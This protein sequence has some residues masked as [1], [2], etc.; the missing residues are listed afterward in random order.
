MNKLHR[1]PD[2]KRFLKQQRDSPL[3]EGMDILSLL[4]TPVQRIPRYLLLLRELQKYT[5]SSH[6]HSHSIIAAIAKVEKI[7]AH[8]NESQRHHEN[9]S[10]L[11]EFQHQIHNLPEEI[12]LFQ[13]HRRLV[14]HGILTLLKQEGTATQSLKSS[15]IGGKFGVILFNDQCIYTTQDHEYRGLLKLQG[16]TL[17]IDNLVVEL[18]KPKSEIHRVP[19]LLRFECPSLE[20]TEKWS[21]SLREG[22]QTANELNEKDERRRSAASNS[23]SK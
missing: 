8:I 14:R 16:C 10:I 3:S 6:P 22:I 9:A 4:I 1:N 23:I 19:M 20:E 21:T 2:F 7:A 15:D 12:I 13:P 18:Y 11:L 5:P 17:N